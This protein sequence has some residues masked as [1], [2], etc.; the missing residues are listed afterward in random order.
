MKLTHII[1]LAIVTACSSQAYALEIYKGK[2]TNHKEWSTGGAKGTFVSDFGH[3]SSLKMRRGNNG[4]NHSSAENFAGSIIAHSA[5]DSTTVNQPTVLPNSNDVYFYN[6]SSEK[7][8]YTYT[9]GSCGQDSKEIVQC[10]F[11]ENTVELEP[12]GY[13]QDS[14]HPTLELTYTKPGR[15]LFESITQNLEGNHH[16][17]VSTSIATMVVS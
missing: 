7:Q 1:C 8:T 6:D 12:N 2:V 17:G 16:H 4:N 13:I 5:S 14:S 11:F 9:F 10:I 3:A 15:Y